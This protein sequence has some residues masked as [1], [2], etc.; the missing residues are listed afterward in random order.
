[1]NL[2][3]LETATVGQHFASPIEYGDMTGLTDHEEAQVNRWL[4]AYPNATFKWGEESE[5]ARC[6]ITGLMS[7]CVEVEIYVLNN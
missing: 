6:E 5:F 1:M 4:S 7:N 2:E 3:L